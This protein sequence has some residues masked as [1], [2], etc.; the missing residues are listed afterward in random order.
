MQLFFQNGVIDIDR[1]LPKAVT[2]QDQEAGICTVSQFPTQAVQMISEMPSQFPSQSQNSRNTANDHVGSGV[3]NHE[4]ES[5]ILIPGKKA[6]LMEEP[7]LCNKVPAAV[8]T[9]IHVFGSNFSEDN[10]LKDVGE[11]RHAVPD[12]AAAIEDLLEQTSKVKML[13][14]KWY[15]V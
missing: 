13:I 11:V 2:A 3:G 1:F 12:V 5:K 8:N 7:G 10:M 4:T 6:R 15:G 9:G 14:C